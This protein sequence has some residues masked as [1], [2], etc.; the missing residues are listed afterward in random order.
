MD[1]INKNQPEDNRKDLS[2]EGAI[3]KMKE[4]LKK[5][6]PVFSVPGSK[7]MRAFLHALCLFGK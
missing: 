1:S 4:L 2:G 5:Q 6:T 3:K 7:R